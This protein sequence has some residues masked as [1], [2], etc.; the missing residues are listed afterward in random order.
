M[1]LPNKPPQ[2]EL[3]LK[4]CATLHKGGA[5]ESHFTRIFRGESEKDLETELWV[6]LDKMGKRGYK[7]KSYVARIHD[8]S[9]LN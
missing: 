5:P 6:W 8:D 9:P 2:D 1:V 7:V 4:L 3:Q